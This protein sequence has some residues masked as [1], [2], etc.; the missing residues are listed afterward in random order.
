MFR[1]DAHA[2]PDAVWLQVQP[3]GSAR[4]PQAELFVLESNSEQ[5]PEQLQ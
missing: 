4:V 5:S 1:E 3:R 2:A